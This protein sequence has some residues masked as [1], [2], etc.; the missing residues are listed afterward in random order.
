M[1]LSFRY[2]ILI[3]INLDIQTRN[4]P[5]PPKEDDLVEIFTFSSVFISTTAIFS[6]V[7]NE[8]NHLY[9]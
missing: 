3:I 4:P 7:N 8:K 9:P 6:S 1:A 5:L 2:R